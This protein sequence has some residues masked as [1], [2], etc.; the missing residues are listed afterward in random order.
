MPAGEFDGCFGLVVS[1][2]ERMASSRSVSAVDAPCIG[3]PPAI[4]ILVAAVLDPGPGVEDRETGLEPG[5]EF[6]LDLDFGTPRSE[7]RVP[8]AEG[9]GLDGGGVADFDGGGVGPSAGC[10]GVD[11]PDLAGI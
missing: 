5:L 10:E 2:S 6:G 3:V 11:V 9:G 8:A 4:E 1:S 7:T